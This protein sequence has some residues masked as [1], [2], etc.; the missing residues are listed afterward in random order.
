V[1][2]PRASARRSAFTLI[3][4]LVVIAIIAVLI[5]MLL[6][7]IQKVRAAAARAR[8][9][10]NLHQIGV[11]V[12]HI[13][14]DFGGLPPLC[15][16]SAVSPMPF[17]GPFHGMPYTFH[18]WLLPYLE[19]GNVF[20][21]CWPGGYAGG[22]YFQVIPPYICP[23]DPSEAG[24]MCQTSYGG[25]NHWGGSS[26]LA[27]YLTFGDPAAGRVEGQS[28]LVS[29]F[30]RGLSNTII[31]TEGYV[32]C[33]WTNDL[34]F[35][36]GSL[37]ADSNSVWRPIFGTNTSYKSP[38]GRGYPAVFKFQ[39]TP[40]WRTGCDPSRAQSPHNAGINVL[41]ADGTVRFLTQ[42]ISDA[43]WHVA[44]DPRTTANLGNDW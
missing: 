6:P 33:G 36:Y 20:S 30:P 13:D 9:G 24:G 35:M 39:V 32:T 2:T 14:G 25:A 12:H 7:A 27:N 1:S 26:Y 38:N 4:L 44:C 43:T 17:P 23:S 37:W 18:C 21:K 31:F 3:E 5:G 8:C 15:T 19:Q 22:Q 11:A 34:T 40:D 16:A 42:N 28:R 41:L 10:N 29:S